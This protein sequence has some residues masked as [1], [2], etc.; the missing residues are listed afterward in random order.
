VDLVLWRHAEPTDGARDE[1]RI[2]TEHGREQAH[3]V[4][5]W[6]RQRLP[7][8]FEV[9]TSPL[10]RARQTASHL[11]DKAKVE[12][13]VG[14]G[15]TAESLLDAVFWPHGDGC[16]VVVAHQPTLGQTAALLLT[17]RERGITVRKGAA[18][19]F[20]SSGSGS[21]SGAKLLAVIDPDHLF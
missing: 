11:S 19:W 2:L 9:V 16:V 20:R 5:T 14:S 21:L 4:G 8:G 12:P 6:L 13:R 3:R 15:V 1:E 10:A 7:E 17:G 18:W